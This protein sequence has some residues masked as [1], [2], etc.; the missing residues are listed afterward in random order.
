AGKHDPQSPD[1]GS[2]VSLAIRF[3]AIAVVVVTVPGW[4]VWSI[5][6]DDLV[7][8]C[9]RLGDQRVARRDDAKADEFKKSGI[10]DFAFVPGAA[11]VVDFQRLAFVRLPILGDANIVLVRILSRVGYCPLG[12]L[13]GPLIRDRAPFAA[14]RF[15]AVRAGDVGGTDQAGD[16]GGN[17]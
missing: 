3:F 12:K 17:R 13:F 9:D 15:I 10:D 14:G 4:T 7:H 6:L 1:T 8:N 5:D 2:I 11:A 16:F